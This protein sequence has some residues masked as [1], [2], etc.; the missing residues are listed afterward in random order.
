[1]SERCAIFID[2]GY[3]EKILLN[4]FSGT[5]IDYEKLVDELTGSD[6]R[7]RAYYYNCPP[8]AGSTPTIDEARRQSQADRF[9]QALR[10]L[11]RFEVRLGKLARRSCDACG[12]MIFQQRRVDIK[13]AVDLVSLS[14]KN[15]INK[16]VLIAGDSDLIP[17]VEAAKDSG[18]VVHLYNGGR[19]SPPHRDLFELCDER[20]EIAQALI[21]ACLRA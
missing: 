11:P 10:M 20:T 8:F 2:A 3:F 12:N 5:R 17:A 9:Y 13:I 4:D 6:T 16:A 19:Q 14:A 1:M 7:L 18:V 15:T 21:D